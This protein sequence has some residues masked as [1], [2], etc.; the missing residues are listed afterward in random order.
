M[1]VPVDDRWEQMLGSFRLR[2]RFAVWGESNVRPG[3]SGETIERP[4]NRHICILISRNSVLQRC[5]P[6]YGIHEHVYNA[7]KALFV[8]LARLML[9]TN[10]R[11]L[12]GGLAMYA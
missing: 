3:I 8:L 10:A 2:T 6:F 11:L 7:A 9:Y 4:V 5:G 1:Q 12:R